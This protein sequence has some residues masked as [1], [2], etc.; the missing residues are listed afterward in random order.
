MPPKIKPAPTKLQK[1]EAPTQIIRQPEL[2]RIPKGPIFRQNVEYNGKNLELHQQIRA[3][4][5]KLHSCKLK[6]FKFKSP[7]FLK[8][9]KYLKKLKIDTNYLPK[10]LLSSQFG[11]FLK[12]CESLRLDSLH[13]AYHP[14]LKPQHFRVFR[15]FRNSRL[16]DF[17]LDMCSYF[18]YYSQ[19]NEIRPKFLNAFRRLK[20][21]N[22]LLLT[23][24]QIKM[25]LNT[26]KLLSW[27]KLHRCGPIKPKSETETS[28]RWVL[29]NIP[30]SLVKIH[31]VL[32]P[33]LHQ[34]KAPDLPSLPNLRKLG[35]VLDYSSH[36]YPYDYETHVSNFSFIKNLP[37]LES[38]NIKLEKCELDSL[39][40]LVDLPCLKELAFAYNQSNTKQ[41][42]ILNLPNLVNLEILRLDLKEPSILAIDHITSLI[43]N[44]PNLRSLDLNLSIQNL[45]VIF[46]GD[47]LFLPRLETLSIDINSIQKPYIE[48]AQNIAKALKKH[49]FV[50]KLQINLEQSHADLNEVLL[51]GGLAH[52]KS[53]QDLTLKCEKAGGL[54]GKK[55]QYLKDVFKNLVSLTSLE[56]D[57]S[58]DLLRPPEINSFL[59]D[60]GQLKNLKKF[61]LSARLLKMTRA[62]LDQLSSY[63]VSIKHFKN[64]QIRLK[65]VSQKEEN[66]LKNDL[67]IKSALATGSFSFD[68]KI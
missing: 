57:V 42:P 20:K 46:A 48:E 9:L 19:Q 51:E 11:P 62:N 41:R 37:K 34:N 16:R 40:F 47:D 59:V 67:F 5:W 24:E 43:S 63:L 61:W 58:S 66:E 10:E 6:Y 23:S 28:S 4:L 12:F 2:K 26:D 27:K 21:C 33:L 18:Y 7:T 55:F 53:V 32:K 3:K 60:L 56:L 52:M 14:K 30:K 39:D 13:L 38:L 45:G 1:Q 65:G 68:P 29:K 54:K 50:E 31:S 15:A 17:T 36:Y 8:S 64:L 44:N 25:L 49:H 22:L 35:L